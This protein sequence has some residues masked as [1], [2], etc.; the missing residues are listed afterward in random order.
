MKKAMVFLFILSVTQ[1][2]NLFSQENDLNNNWLYIGIKAGSNLAFYDT[3][4]SDY[5]IYD[6]ATMVNPNIDFMGSIHFFIPF[7]LFLGIQTEINFI[8]GYISEK[9][10][11]TV[12]ENGI[13]YQGEFENVVEI[14]YFLIPILTRFNYIYKIFNFTGLAG[15]YFTIPLQTSQFG[16]SSYNGNSI[17]L[18]YGLGHDNVENYTYKP[19]IGLMFGFNFGIKLGLGRI[20]LDMR[21]GF[22]INVLKYRFDDYDYMLN[23]NELYRKSIIPISIGYEIGIFRK[24]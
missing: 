5:I 21:Y 1:I 17:G 14:N 18:G 22:D 7:F 13:E 9:K 15:I 16:V 12:I 8:S 11:I 19:T 4:K 23:I 3:V 6:D 20:F 24:K 2:S 10:N